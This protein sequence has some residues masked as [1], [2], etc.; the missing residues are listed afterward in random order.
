MT[1]L[2]SMSS[3]SS[4]IQ[5]MG[6]TGATGKP[7]LQQSFA[8]TMVTAEQL[9][10]H[11]EIDVLAKAKVVRQ[12]VDENGKII[13]NFHENPMCNKRVCECESPDGTI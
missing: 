13:G 4:L 12:S 11:G 1:Y 6:M 5:T 3:M 7:I 8:D 2:V 9:L 10:P